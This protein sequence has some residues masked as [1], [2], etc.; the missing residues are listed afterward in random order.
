M[1]KL[2]FITPMRG[3][4][5]LVGA[6][7]YAS[8]PARLTLGP[9]RRFTI[10]LRALHFTA[11]ALRDLQLSTAV[12]PGVAQARGLDRRFARDFSIQHELTQRLYTRAD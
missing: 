9:P 8:T 10:G 1:G 2:L 6:Y 12:A 5:L 4:P 7:Q 3:P 11:A